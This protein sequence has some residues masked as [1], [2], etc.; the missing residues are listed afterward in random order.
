MALK[1]CQTPSSLANHSETY[2]SYKS[3]TTFKGLVGI[4]PSG[5]V[6]FI[7]QLKVN[8]LAIWRTPENRERLINNKTCMSYVNWMPTV[9]PKSRI[10]F[11]SFVLMLNAMPQGSG[12]LLAAMLRS[13]LPTKLLKNV[14]LGAACLLRMSPNLDAVNFFFLAV[15]RFSLSRWV[16]VSF[17]KNCASA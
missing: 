14:G 10:T 6:T 15:H 16:T 13:W 1:E 11:H 8:Y 5:Q 4:A 2:S 9:L 3:H 12:V 7:S 17:S